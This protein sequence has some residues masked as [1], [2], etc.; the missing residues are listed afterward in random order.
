MQQL[1]RTDAWFQERRGKVTASVAGTI[2]GVN[3]HQKPLQPWRQLMGVDEPFKGNYCTHWGE[4]NEHNG[5]LKY[6]CLTGTFVD[7]TGF[8]LHKTYSWLGG[9]PDGLINGKGVLEVKCPLSKNVWKL[10]T[11][12]AQYY[13][14][15][16][17]LMEVT[18]R[19][20]A[21][22]FVW[23]PQGSQVVCFKRNRDFFAQIMP[24]LVNFFT[25]LQT[26]QPPPPHPDIR[27]HVRKLIEQD[28]V[29]W[30]PGVRCKVQNLISPF[31]QFDSN[32]IKRI[33]VVERADSEAERKPCDSP[34]SD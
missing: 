29:P 12:P 21:H 20:W 22:M 9:S 23:R 26:N 31:S 6:Q 33:S 1:Q 19:D 14:Q 27:H 11:L 16:Q 28:V 34:Q 4:V 10:E 8:H 25:A 30:P 17:I 5:V 3:S 2:I 13:V 15:V 7:L 32:G 24:T 18:D